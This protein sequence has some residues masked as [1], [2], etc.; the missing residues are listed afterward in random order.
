MGEGH[1]FPQG[2]DVLKE[3][4]LARLWRARAHQARGRFAQRGKAGP[5]RCK[6]RAGNCRQHGEDRD[7]RIDAQLDIRHLIHDLI[8]RKDHLGEEDV[9]DDKA[10]EAS[11]QARQESVED[12]LA[13]DGEAAVAHRLQ[14]T[15]LHALLFDHARHRRQAHERRHEEEDHGEDACKVRHALGVLAVARVAGVIT[16]AEEIPLAA[17][18]VRDLTAGVGDLFLCVGDLFVRLGLAVFILAQARAVVLF[19]ALQLRVGLGQ[20]LFAVG[21]FLFAVVVFL[22]AVVQLLAR[23]A[24]LLLCLLKLRG[25]IVELCLRLIEL[26]LACGKL[27]AARGKLRAAAA[28]R[29]LSLVKLLLALRD[30]P[31][32]DIL[33]LGKL[34]LHLRLL[35]LCLRKP[36]LRLGKTLFI[37]R[38]LLVAE[39]GVLQ[40]GAQLRDLSVQCVDRALRLRNAR[41]ELRAHSVERGVRRRG[42]RLVALAKI[43]DQ[44]IRFALIG[45]AAA[46]ERAG[47]GAAQRI[48]LLLTLVQLLLALGK[49][50]RAGIELLLAL[51]VFLL[52]VLILGKTLFIFRDGL[53]VLGKAVLILL[54]AVLQLGLGIVELHARIGKLLLTISVVP[55]AVVELFARV[56]ELLLRV[57]ELLVGL[58]LRLV[59]LLLRIVELL[60]RFFHKLVVTKLCARIGKVLKRVDHIVDVIVVVVIKG[61]HLRRAGNAHVG[62]RIVVERKGVARQIQVCPRRAAADRGGAAL[63]RD[64]HRRAHGADHRVSIVRERILHLAARREGNGIADGD[65]KKAQHPLFH[66][67]LVRARGHPALAQQNVADALL[68]QREDLHDCLRPAGGGESVEDI[69]ALCVLNIF[70][71]LERVDILVR[72]S[73]GREHLKVRQM[74]RIE[75]IVARVLHVRRGRLES[76]KERHRQ[77]H[78][79]HDRKKAALRVS[80]LAPEILLHCAFHR[81]ALLFSRILLTIRS[82]PRSA[83]FRCAASTPPCR[84]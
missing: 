72:Q 1:S 83:A 18:N 71:F 3:D 81:A 28:V 13:R 6:G 64:I 34:L 46:V 33:E 22:P 70:L 21:V 19:A 41:R 68:A 49:L 79:D 12:V 43:F 66:H 78:Q 53:L 14:R 35:R 52:A 80:D 30:A 27:A 25:H 45:R 61:R 50:L 10:D 38:A 51:F 40:R 69:L 76:R 37:A 44:L 29:C 73:E 58:R 57:A 32:V 8:G 47:H 20:L 56:P 54:L 36:R 24:Q 9:T 82:F 11:R 5:E 65:V 42:G 60:R 77:R 55:P 84:S 67:A 26:L 75:I 74:Q 17:F 62:R 2:A 16:A 59:Q 23:V 48:E 31:G 7:P 15:D 63:H 39:I 4:A